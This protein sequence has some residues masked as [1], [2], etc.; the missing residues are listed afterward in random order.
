MFDIP[1]EYYRSLSLGGGHESSVTVELAAD[2]NLSH[3]LLLETGICH[4]EWP[5]FSLTSVLFTCVKPN[6]TKDRTKG[7]NFRAVKH[8]PKCSTGTALLHI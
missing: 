3:M 2:S 1:S 6:T 7:L 5:S 8:F 4:E